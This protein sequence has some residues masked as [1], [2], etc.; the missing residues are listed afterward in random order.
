LR[1]EGRWR[2]RGRNEMVI[3]RGWEGMERDGKEADRKMIGMG[4]KF[5]GK[6][7]GKSSSSE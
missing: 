5:R 6:F 7:T 3:G 2:E 1:K 4:S